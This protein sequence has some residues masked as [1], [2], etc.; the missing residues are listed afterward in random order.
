M[1]PRAQ[2]AHQQAKL[3]AKNLVNQ[4]EDKPLQDFRYRDHGSLVSL[5][6]Y[7]AVGNLMRSGASKGLFL[8][9]WLARKAYASLY[10]THQLSIH[11]ATKTGLSW[12]VDKL[13][14]YLKPRMKLH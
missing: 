3:L 12:L 14:K 1:P 7:D 8:E 11:G 10:R 13:N 6:R 4:L 5:A 9:G 2:A